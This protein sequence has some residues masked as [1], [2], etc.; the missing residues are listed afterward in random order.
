MASFLNLGA[1]RD[2]QTCLLVYVLTSSFRP[3]ESKNS[4]EGFEPTIMSGHDM[5]SHPLSHRHRYWV[6]Q[7]F[8]LSQMSAD[9]WKDSQRGLNS[10]H[11]HICVMLLS[12]ELLGLHRRVKVWH[13]ASDQVTSSRGMNP[14]CWAHMAGHLTLWA[15]RSRQTYLTFWSSA[16]GQVRS[17]KESWTHDVKQ[18]WQIFLP[19]ELWGLHR[20]AWLCQGFDLQLPVRWHLKKLSKGFQD[21]GVQT[22]NY[23]HTWEVL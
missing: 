6:H 14:Q 5:S 2:T 21:P 13:L 16:S 19:T 1:I 15:T 3:S 17:K 22:H 11:L 18:T 4:F 7:T 8:D 23:V 12:S 20:A 10:Q 9:V